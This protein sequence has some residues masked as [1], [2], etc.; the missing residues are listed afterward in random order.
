MHTYSMEA[1]VKYAKEG[2]RMARK[3]R[4]LPQTLVRHS[5]T[6]K[7]GR[8]VVCINADDKADIDEQGPRYYVDLGRQR[9]SIPERYL[10]AVIGRVKGQ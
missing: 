3:P 6:G 9:W 2:A 1:K 8:V 7:T 10:K 5:G 4:Y